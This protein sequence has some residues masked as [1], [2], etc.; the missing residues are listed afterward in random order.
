MQTTLVSGN[1][2]NEYQEGILNYL[3]QIQGLKDE[4]KKANNLNIVSAEKYL[5]SNGKFFE[6]KISTSQDLLNVKKC[7]KRLSGKPKKKQCFYNAQQLALY[8]EDK[9]IKYFEGYAIS[10]INFPIHHGWNEINGKVVDVTW[11]FDGN[12]PVIGEIPKGWAYYGV[13]FTKEQIQTMWTKTSEAQAFLDMYG[14]KNNLF[15]I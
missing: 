11:D 6:S 12:T 4:Y 8:C 7:L 3:L 1:K 9:G 10:G 15:T 14:Y 5:L 13:E 2:V